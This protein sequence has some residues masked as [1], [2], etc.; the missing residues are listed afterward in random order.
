LASPS[1]PL[2]DRLAV[3]CADVGSIKQGRFGWARAEVPAGKIDRHRGGTE[4]HELVDVLSEDLE[5][6]LPVA[7]AS[8]VHSSFP[9]RSRR[10][11]WRRQGGRR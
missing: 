1:P 3:Y 5:A 7:L 9:F 2:V 6:D 10:S 11:G 8:S 4:I